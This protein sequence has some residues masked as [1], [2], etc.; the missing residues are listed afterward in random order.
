MTSRFRRFCANRQIKLGSPPG[1]AHFVS[2]RFPPCRGQHLRP[3]I[4]G[5]T[6]FLTEDALC[7]GQ[8]A[9]LLQ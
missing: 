1:F 5:S 4:A 3:G 2:L 6:M 9:P 7:A 8:R